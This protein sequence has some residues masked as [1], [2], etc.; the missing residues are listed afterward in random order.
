ML[1]V[2]VL[3]IPESPVHTVPSFTDDLFRM[4]ADIKLDYFQDKP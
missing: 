2:I 4:L 3:L 1:F